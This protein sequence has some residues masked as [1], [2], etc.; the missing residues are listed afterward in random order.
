MKKAIPQILNYLY[1]DNDISLDRKM[2]LAT[3]IKKI[4]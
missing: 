3:K 2:E 4:C 1:Q